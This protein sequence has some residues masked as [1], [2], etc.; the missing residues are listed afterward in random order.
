M[1]G[2][3]GKVQGK[4]EKHSRLESKLHSSTDGLGGKLG[5]ALGPKNISETGKVEEPSGVEKTNKMRVFGRGRK[6]NENVEEEEEEDNNDKEVDEE[7]E[8]EE[9]EEEEEEEGILKWV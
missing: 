6:K 5:W 9:K 3:R 7:E 8:E 2:G 1:L 4:L